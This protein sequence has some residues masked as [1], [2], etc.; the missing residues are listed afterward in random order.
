MTALK[1]STRR[2]AALCAAALAGVLT[3][4]AASAAQN[5]PAPAAPPSADGRSSSKQGEQRKKKPRHAN[6]F[7]VHGSVFT[8]SGLSFPGVLLRVRRTSEK[9]FR[10]ETATDSR[11]EF[12]IRVPQGVD[13]EIVA[14]A[15]KFREQ[16]RTVDAKSGARDE[17][18]VFRMETAAGGKS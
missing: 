14:Q 13:Y 1:I 7:L 17:S 5:A 12:A 6:D 18:L 3:A 11:G 9:K 16:R 4:T 10:W 15:K 2:C 8:P